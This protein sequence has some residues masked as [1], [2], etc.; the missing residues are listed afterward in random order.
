[1][2]FSRLGSRALWV[3]APVVM[4]VAFV[5]YVVLAVLIS[6]IRIRIG[7][8]RVSSRQAPLPLRRRVDVE[9]ARIRLI[10]RD[11]DRLDGIRLQRVPS[12]FRIIARL[13]DGGDRVL[14]WG[15]TLAEAE[16]LRHAIE[17]HLGLA[18][19]LA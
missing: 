12:T 11:P 19:R 17:N 6:P 10:V 8:L 16:Y 14:A 18:D 3:L 13:D 4:F 2:W 15:L 7:P 1:M 5:A 9:T